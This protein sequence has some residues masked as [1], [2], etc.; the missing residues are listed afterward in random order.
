MGPILAFF[1]LPVDKVNMLIP[2]DF[3][4]IVRSEI[5]KIMS[6]NKGV[7]INGSLLG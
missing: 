1:L 3:W 7:N 5:K 6:L 4:P 2:G